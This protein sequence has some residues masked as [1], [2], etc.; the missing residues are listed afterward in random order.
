MEYENIRAFTKEKDVG[1][2]LKFIT[3]E[4]PCVVDDDNHRAY[5]LVKSLGYEYMTEEEAEEADR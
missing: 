2:Q 5:E 3:T 4:N 1:E